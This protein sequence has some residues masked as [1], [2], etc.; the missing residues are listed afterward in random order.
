[1]KI[2]SFDIKPLLMYLPDDPKWVD[3]FEKAKEYLSGQGVDG[4]EYVAGVHGSSWG[5]STTHQYLIDG[6]PE[7]NYYIDSGKVGGTLTYFIL[8][9]IMNVLPDEYFLILE[10]DVRFADGWKEKLEAALGACNDF[11]FMFV[12][13]CCTD[14]KEPIRIG[15]S[16][17]YEFDYKGEVK[18]NWYPMCGH[19]FIVNKKCVPFLIQTQ[20]DSGMPTD[21]ML[22]KNAF[23]KLKI[24]AILPR[25]ADQGEKTFLSP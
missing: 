5:L 4:I 6:R 14:N 10:G 1:M 2:G 23:P 9:S 8:Y 3:E 21:V 19:A 13:S 25:L 16:D 15:E 22:I 11:D 17:V 7:E 20:R 18:W 12:G 24:V